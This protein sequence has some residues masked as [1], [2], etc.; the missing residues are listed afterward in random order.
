MRK[1]VLFFSALALFLSLGGTSRAVDDTAANLIPEGKISL[2]KIIDTLNKKFPKERE[3]FWNVSGIAYH[4]FSGV[5]QTDVIVGLAGYR[6]RGMTYNSG[7]Q[8]VEDA[9][10]GFAY[11][12]LGKEE[13]ELVQVELVEG[14]KYIGFEGADLTGS[15]QDQLVV[16]S[17]TD[18]KQIAT[19]YALPEKGTF[20]KIATIAGYGMGPR[21]AQEGGK[22][23]MVDFQRALVNRCEDC[24]IYYGRA[25]D[26]DGHG[27]TEQKDEFLDQVQAY[28]PF[29]STE[30]ETSQSLAFFENYLS[31]HPTD[32]CAMANCFDLSNRLGLKDKMEDYHK[33]LVQL[34]DDSLGCRYCDE[35]LM[36]KNRA[37]KEEYLD[38]ISGKKATKT[39]D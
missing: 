14:K 10:A 22:P 3:N 33:R 39:S 6:D 29:K 12:H 2:T 37:M 4:D 30:A 16:Y 26:W 8:L 38:M 11:F 36:N 25:Y 18:E 24:G 28:D 32:F 31:A 1:K 5:S 17:S 7:K 23:M 19:V 34:R 35:W 21:V 20:K 27:F 9:G 13:W 15:G